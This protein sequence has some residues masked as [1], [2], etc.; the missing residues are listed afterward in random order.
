MKHHSQ[1]TPPKKKNFNFF[2]QN[3]LLKK[4]L[5]GKWFLFR[6]SCLMSLSF[7]TSISP[8]W[9]LRVF[10]KTNSQF[11]CS[12][13]QPQQQ[14]IKSNQINK[15]HVCVCLRARAWTH[16]VVPAVRPR[17]LWW[18]GGTWPPAE[19]RWRRWWSEWSS[20]L[21]RSKH[22]RSESL[23]TVSL[24]HGVCQTAP[25]GVFFFVFFFP[26]LSNNTSIV[27]HRLFFIFYFF[28]F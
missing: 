20:F 16:C 18:P 4:I 10:L 3:N 26:L 11:F 23:P 9:N 17:W 7:S 21:Q 15:Q 24:F 12:A 22:S 2:L 5:W 14:Q 25:V 8:Q 27:C 1:T 19:V 28:L 6:G 13:F